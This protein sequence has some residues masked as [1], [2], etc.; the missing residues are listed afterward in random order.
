MEDANINLYH[1]G[2]YG[3]IKMIKYVVYEI[4]KNARNYDSCLRGNIPKQKILSVS[5]PST[6]TSDASRA[7]HSSGSLSSRLDPLHFARSWS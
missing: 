5:A 7:I 6:S 3:L 2:S 4:R 1:K